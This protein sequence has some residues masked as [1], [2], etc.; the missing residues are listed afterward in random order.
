ML[1]SLYAFTPDFGRSFLLK[2]FCIIVLG[3]MESVTGVAAGALVLAFLENALGGLDDAS[4]VAAGRRELHAPLRDARRV[5]AGAPGLSPPARQDGLPVKRA[6]ARARRGRSRPARSRRPALPRARDAERRLEPRVR[7]HPRVGVEHPRGLRGPGL[8]RLLGVPRDRRL[9]DRPPLAPGREPVLDAAPRRRSSRRSSRSSIGLPAFRLRGPYFTIATIG[10][11]EAVRVVGRERVVHGRLERP[12]D[13]RGLLRLHAQLRGDGRPRDRDRS[14]SR[15]LV[16]R[17]AFGHA[18][19]AIKQ[20]ID[21]AEALGVGSTRFKLGAHALSAALVA[22]AGSL[23]AINFQ[24]IAPGSVFDFR[25][26]LAIVLAPDRRRR[27]HRRGTRSRGDRL[28]DAPDQAPVRSR[29]SATPTSSSTE[30]SSS[31]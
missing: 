7:R 6:P 3:G 25:L 31:S 18:L 16:K 24:Y 30:G 11:G 15:P 8:A 21:A 29:P 9:H 19:A 23:Y 20:D 27:R 4:D 14:A 5:A 28:L 12:E 1:S 17:S 26:S 13:A 22:L 10:V 2:A